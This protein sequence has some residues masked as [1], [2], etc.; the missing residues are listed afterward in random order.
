MSKEYDTMSKEYDTMSKN[1]DYMSE[2]CASILKE[3]EALN[4]VLD[5]KNQENKRQ[6]EEILRLK[7]LLSEK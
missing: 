1:Y 2:K 6:A 7:K 3:K 5:E 4:I